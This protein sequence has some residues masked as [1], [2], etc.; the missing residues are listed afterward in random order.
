M[1]K[2]RKLLNILKKIIFVENGVYYFKDLS[3]EYIRDFDYIELNIFN[4]VIINLID[5]KDRLIHILA[6]ELTRFYDETEEDIIKKLSE[7]K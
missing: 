3:N 2:K 1:K 7:E 4:K 6:K 5:K